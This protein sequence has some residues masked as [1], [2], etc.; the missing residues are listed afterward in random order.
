MLKGKDSDFFSEARQTKEWAI[1]AS[2]PSLTQEDCDK[3]RIWRDSK[4]DR[5]VI[6]I[7]TSFRLAPWADILYACDADWW[8]KYF[9][10]ALRDFKGEMWTQDPVFG[11]KHPIRFIQSKRCDGLGRDVI[12]T[13][14]NGGYQSINL[15][16]LFGAKS[17]VLLGFDMKR[18]DD[19]KSHWHGDHPGG[20][21]KSCPFKT[22]L[23]NFPRLA[24]D[25]ESEGVNVVNAT[26]D[27]A[28]NCFPRIELE[29]LC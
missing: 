20:L 3:V 23:N 15:A 7:N 19:K 10:E 22:W 18:G 1:I 14:G 13:G 11:K 5:S 17:I 9:D 29:T 24:Q 6:V 21:N 27:T 2:G 25:L 16:Y 4:E 12:H 28:L 26:R 8:R